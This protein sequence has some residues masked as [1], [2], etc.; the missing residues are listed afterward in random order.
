MFPSLPVSV[1]VR[2]ARDCAGCGAPAEVLGACA[3]GAE[4]AQALKT[5]VRIN[6]KVPTR[7]RCPFCR[8]S[9]LRRAHTIQIA[10]GPSPSYR[11]QAC[12]SH[13]TIYYLLYKHYL[14]KTN[15]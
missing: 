4:V 10:I 11:A 13:I 6:I 12:I 7:W 15:A 14:G 3:C 2:G 8:I 9:V 5:D 1:S